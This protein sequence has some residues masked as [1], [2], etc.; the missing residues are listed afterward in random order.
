MVLVLPHSTFYNDFMHRMT[1]LDRDHLAVLTSLPQ[2]VQ[3]DTQAESGTRG[4]T[5]CTPPST[6]S[7]FAIP[8]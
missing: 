8:A 2:A 1:S 5:S 6:K 3:G 4:T 7:H